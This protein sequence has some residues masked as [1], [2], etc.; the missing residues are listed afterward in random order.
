MVLKEKY[1][2][3]ITHHVRALKYPVGMWGLRC[4]SAWRKI[5]HGGY[6][7]EALKAPSLSWVSFVKVVLLRSMLFVVLSWRCLYPF[8]WSR[9]R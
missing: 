5:F 8:C 9:S 1:D 4:I 3:A 7:L 6:P 2:I